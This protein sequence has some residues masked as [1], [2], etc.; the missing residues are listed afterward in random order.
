MRN[1]LNRQ[2]LWALLALSMLTSSLLAQQENQPLFSRQQNKYPTQQQSITPPSFGQGKPVKPAQGTKAHQLV[3]RSDIET[4][5]QQV[6]GAGKGELIESEREEIITKFER[7][8]NVFLHDRDL[9]IVSELNAKELVNALNN[10]VNQSNTNSDENKFNFTVRQGL[11]SVPGQSFEDLEPYNKQA[12]LNSLR[13]GNVPKGVKLPGLTSTNVGYPNNSANTYYSPSGSQK[14]VG[15]TENYQSQ[16]SRSPYTVQPTPPAKYPTSYSESLASGA[17]QPLVNKSGLPDEIFHKLSQDPQLPA[18]NSYIVRALDDRAKEFYSNG[19]PRF[20]DKGN[21]L[22][23]NGSRKFNN[24][25]VPL[26]SNGRPKV[27]AQGNRLHS[28]GQSMY[29]VDGRELYPNGSPKITSTGVAV[30]KDGSRK[31]RGN[32]R[33]PAEVIS[34]FGKPTSADQI[35]LGGS[36]DVRP[37]K[38]VSPRQALDGSEVPSSLSQAERRLTTQG[39]PLYLNG[40]RMVTSD[41]V[42]L[43]PNGQARFTGDGQGGVDEPAIPQASGAPAAAELEK[44]LFP[45]SRPASDEEGNRLYS[46]GMPRSNEQGQ[47]LYANGQR[48]TAANNAALTP[49]GSRITGTRGFLGRPQGLFEMYYVYEGRIVQMDEKQLVLKPTRGDAVTFDLEGAAI[50]RDDQ[51]GFMPGTVDQLTN[52]LN[53]KVIGRFRE[54]FVDGRLVGTADVGEAVSIL[55]SNP[56]V[57][58]QIEDG[59]YPV[60]YTIPATV[61]RVSPSELEVTP[62]TGPQTL[63]LP[64]SIDTLLQ[65]RQ[66]GETIPASIQTVGIGRRVDL[67]VQQEVRVQNNKLQSTGPQQ[68]LA[69]IQ[70]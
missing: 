62:T 41:G 20:D 22:Y 69:V 35:D 5:V 61:R 54:N 2:T 56:R 63:Q 34:S 19:R 11:R 14:T 24:R 57:G 43:H 64:I 3:D 10:S 17:T 37:P 23:P 58:R 59:T 15:L 28:N 60:I 70:N 67:I 21:E 26:Y 8:Y 27:D 52:R 33:D 50:A 6:S 13:F 66:L 48:L 68:V 18:A 32:G 16:I 46:N 51:S 29:T 40:Q 25:G 1:G 36:K 31:F 30:F 12:F 45:N 7:Q 9:L 39:Q 38:P 49:A 44:R 65:K 53:V 55:A 42:K 47:P 4:F